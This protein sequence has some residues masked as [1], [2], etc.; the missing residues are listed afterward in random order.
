V[1]KRRD[2][3]EPVVQPARNARTDGK[4][5]VYVS[6]DAGNVGVRPAGNSRADARTDVYQSA[7]DDRE[8]R[9]KSKARAGASTDVFKSIDI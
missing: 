4:T 9:S 6:A 7:D 8:S 1:R 3:V 5:D 2:S